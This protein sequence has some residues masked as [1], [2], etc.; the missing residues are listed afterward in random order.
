MSNTGDFSDSIMNEAGSFGIEKEDAV[1]TIKDHLERRGFQI[2]N[3]E[4]VDIIADKGN[5]R[6]LIEVKTP[7]IGHLTLDNIAQ[8][9]S[10]AKAYPG[11]VTP[12]IIG[13]FTAHG[14]TENVAARNNIRLI[15]ITKKSSL[16]S[17]GKA[18]DDL[19]DEK[20]TG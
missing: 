1:K 12:I 3:L 14:S 16:E 19:I 2:K 20:V 5:E 7:K 18:V 8:V 17:I 11:K 15:N 10:I 9:N 4:T 13:N 6:I